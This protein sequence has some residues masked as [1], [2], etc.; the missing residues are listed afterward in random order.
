MPGPATPTLCRF[1][2]K[3]HRG[4]PAVAGTEKLPNLGAIPRALRGRHVVL[5]SR[6]GLTGHA[7]DG[8]PSAQARGFIAASGGR[9]LFP[10]Q[11]L[12]VYARTYCVVVERAH[13][14]DPTS[15]LP[16]VQTKGY[17]S[18]GRGAA[19]II[20]AHALVSLCSRSALCN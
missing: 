17:K 16:H 4:I 3:P 11:L 18:G 7:R 8:A 2:R 14:D 6:R 15:P 10:G 1:S 12:R 9:L 19:D 20:L 13:A 5:G